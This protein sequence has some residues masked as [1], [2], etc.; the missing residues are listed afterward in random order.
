M[1]S[2]ASHLKNYHPN[3]P[4]NLN[5]SYNIYSLTNES[6]KMLHKV[7]FQSRTNVHIQI[8]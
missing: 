5:P 7:K 2:G 4:P 8:N 3:P 1:H 6:F